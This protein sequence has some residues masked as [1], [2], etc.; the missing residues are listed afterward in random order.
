MALSSPTVTGMYRIDT[1]TL[2]NFRC[3]AHVQVTFHPRLTVLVAPNGQGK[4]AILDG[5]AMAFRLFVDTL[6]T[7]SG[8]RGFA[9]SDIR[10]ALTADRTMEAMLP[11]ELEAAGIL[12]GQ[13]LTWTHTLESDSSRGR[14]TQVQA[15]AIKEGALRLRLAIQEQA[16]HNGDPPLL[17]LIAYLGAGRMWGGQRRRVLGSTSRTSGYVDSLSPTA[18]FRGFEE[19]FRRFSYEA[20]QEL[21]SHRASPHQPRQRLTAVCRAVETMLKPSGWVQLEWDLAED[22]L[23]ASHTERGRLPVRQQSDG[24]RT[25]IGLSGDLAQRCVRLNPHLGERAVLETPGVVLIDEVDLHLHP[26]WQQAVVGLLSAAFPRVQLI[27]AT[28]SPAVLTTVAADSIRVLHLEDGQAEATVP[29]LQTQGVE[30]S[31]VLAEVM[32]VDPVPRATAEE[33]FATC[34]RHVLQCPDM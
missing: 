25:L 7:R 11:V 9:R 33:P 19:W 1:L 13:P 26:A 16:D 21:E 15:R 31:H 2:R 14:T 27:L 8:S 17:P 32:G 23:S 5:V 20:R 6:L 12:D 4:T 24:I 18:D 30:S 22:A 3:F 34:I 28:H 10:R 29:E